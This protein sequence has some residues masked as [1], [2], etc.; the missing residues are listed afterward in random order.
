MCNNRRSGYNDSSPFSITRIDL[1]GE[2]LAMLHARTGGSSAR[3]A[4]N[5]REVAHPAQGTRLWTGL[6]TMPSMFTSSLVALF[7]LTAT[8]QTNPARL[9]ATI[10]GKRYEGLGSR[11]AVMASQMSPFSSARELR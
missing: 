3:Q 10:R 5:I 8:A 11:V 2:R 4:A 1:Y 6:S 9:H 7:A